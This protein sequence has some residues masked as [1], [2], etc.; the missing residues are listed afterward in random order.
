[1]ARHEKD[2]RATGFH[3][4]FADLAARLR[5]ARGPQRAPAPPPP[6]TPPPPPTPP[7]PAA[8][9]D[10][11]FRSAM[12]GVERLVPDPRGRA[13]APPPAP[14]T[15]GAPRDDDAEAYAQLCDLVQGDGPFDIADTPEYI[16]GLAHG[17]DR[18]LLRRLRRGDY[19]VQGHI[20]LHG[21][22]AQAARDA[23]QQFVGEAR[24]A[25]KRC[26]LI[27]HGRGLNSKDHIPVL[28]ERLRQWLARGRIG[29]SVL[30]FATAQPYD[31]GAGA[32]YVLLRR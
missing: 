10:E 23:V 15:A 4:P 19:A 13:A 24:T 2:S 28:K 5:P 31:G 29:K 14:P 20:D 3:T 18:R 8:S 6:A 17:L 32:V 27:I 11:L 25:G 16:E 21:L 9:D 22:T 1:M 12:G 30:C 7:E 26:V